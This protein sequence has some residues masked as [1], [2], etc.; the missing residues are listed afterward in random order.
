MIYGAYMPKNASLTRTVVGVALLDTFVSL[1]AGVALFPIVFAAGLNPSEG[2]GLMFVSLPFA[3]GS[4]AFGQVMGVVFFSSWWPSQPGVRP[5]P[6]WNPWWLTWL[7]G[8]GSA[9]PG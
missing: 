6:C 8:P 3:F 1:L 5:S 2:P 7:N 9:A 4:M